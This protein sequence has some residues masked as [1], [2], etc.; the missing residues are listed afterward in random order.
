MFAHL[1]PAILT[2]SS[3]KVTAIS[4][5]PQGRI[6]FDVC[7]SAIVGVQVAEESKRTSIL[8]IYAYGWTERHSQDCL[9]GS[10]LRNRVHHAI[11]FITSGTEQ[12]AGVAREWATKINDR[13]YP[14][15]KPRKFLVFVNPISGSGQAVRIWEREVH[16]MLKDA[17]AE[18]K[19]VITERS[20]HARDYMKASEDVLSYDAVL[21]IGGDGLYYEV[22]EQIRNPTLTLT[23]NLTTPNLLKCNFW[24]Y[25]SLSVSLIIFILYVPPYKSF[26]LM[27]L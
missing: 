13:I 19:C 21:S 1:S 25:N 8:H 17:Q 20:N 2:L 24:I 16:Q 22:C 18:Y 6:I 9:H 15:G 7:I 10:M 4:E 27:N 14:G 5:N 11:E 23:L 26:D 12:A 3:E